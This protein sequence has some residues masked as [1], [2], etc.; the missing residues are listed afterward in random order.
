MSVLKKQKST[1]ML[2]IYKILNF[3]LIP[4]IIL[5]V[6]FRLLNGKEDKY[7][8]KE[9][10]GLTSKNNKTS[11]KVIW[12]HAASIGEFKSS[13]FIINNYFKN[14][15][16][17]V[18]TTTKS[19][20]EYVNLNYADKVL[21]QYAPYDVSIWLER[22]I[23]NWNP[24]L[25]L[26]IE[27]DL[28][29]NTLLLLQ[30]Y[31]IKSLYLNARVS[32]K[33]FNKWKLIKP[34]YKKILKTF[35][36]IFAQSLD[37][38]KRIEELSNLKIEY[39]GNLKLTYKNPKKFE[40]K[41]LEEFN[42][43]LASTH[44]NEENILIKSLKKINNK[45]KKVKYFVA[46]R[47]PERSNNVL[48]LFKDNNFNTSLESQ[49]LKTNPGVI[50]IDSFGNM[51]HYFYNSHIVIL[52]GSFSYKGGH[53]PLEP[54]KYNCVIISGDKTFNWQNIYNDMIK[55]NACIIVN[56]PEEIVHI[57]ENLLDNSNSLNN[58]KQNAFNFSCKK[59]FEEE[60]LKDIINKSLE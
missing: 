42:I 50:I 30:K 59:F 7:R 46:P 27:S 48:N 56:Q 47:H 3:L 22:F 24:K 26:W 16:I 44:E 53:N 28:W 8:F 25:V 19:A 11:K 14:Y 4:F 2:K 17:L 34:F 35:N 36:L 49:N 45:Y 1:L 29:P 18:T 33:S 57:I 10:Y 32:P 9:R 51:D 43:M 15:F 5:N 58:F 37:D 54:A 52:G 13:D 20:A 12:I 31:N 6:Y 60:K 39:I 55:E 21:H 38:L 23:K 41:N 40:K